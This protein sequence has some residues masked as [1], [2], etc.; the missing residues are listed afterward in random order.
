MINLPSFLKPTPPPERRQ[1]PR[2][3]PDNV[4]SVLLVDDEP[5]IRSLFAMSLRRD[6]YFVVEAQ[7]GE[8]ALVA[9][10]AAGRIDVVI[11]DIQMPRMDGLKLADALRNAHPEMDVIFVSGH[12]LDSGR[13]GPHTHL[14]NKPFLKDDLMQVV[15]RVAGPSV[16]MH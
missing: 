11:T 6:G 1:V 5:A 3:A 15:T 2:L 8:A 12:P 16:R 14:L 13:I 9:A 4:T 7:D 10:N